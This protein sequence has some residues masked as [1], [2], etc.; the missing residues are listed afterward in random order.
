VTGLRRGVGRWELSLPTARAKARG[1][2]ARAGEAGR[3]K[4]F[5]VLVRIGFLSRALTYGVVGALALALAAGA[6]TDG[7]APDQQGALTLIAGAPLG[8]VALAVLAAGLLAY[9]VWKLA[10]AAAGHGPEGGGGS[11][12]WD[13]VSNGAGGVAYLIFF[14]AAV[15][16]LLGGGGGSSRGGGQGSDS[17]QTHHAAAGLLAW[18]AGPWLVGAGGLALIAVS[19]YQIWDGLSGGFADQAKT[20]EMGQDERRRFLALGRVG[21]TARALVFVLIGYFLLRTAI[22]FD[23]QSA[24]GV[25]GALVRLHHQ[26]YGPWLVGLTGVGLLVFAGYSLLEGRYR[27]L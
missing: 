11:S 12:A 17:G 3:S 16:V 27:R 6:G 14:S 9:A 25:D 20:E 21:I 22:G 8:A 4:S 26:A 19:L 15:R 5:R 10:Q 2:E 24:V 18:P 7:T 1:A 23:A 13:R